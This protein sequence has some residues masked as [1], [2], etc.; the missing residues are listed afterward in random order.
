MNRNNNI[1]HTGFAATIGVTPISL[2]K[3]SALFLSYVDI[4]ISSLKFNATITDA[5]TDMSHTLQPNAI[6]KPECS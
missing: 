4:I 3:L 1:P 6:T 5:S 2:S